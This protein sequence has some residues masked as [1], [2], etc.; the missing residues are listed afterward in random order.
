MPAVTPLIEVL[1]D[2]LPHRLA[3]DLQ[4][5]WESG[6]AVLTVRAVV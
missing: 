4:R 1:E 5:G 2:V 6:T 3:C